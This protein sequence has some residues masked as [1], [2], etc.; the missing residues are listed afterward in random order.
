MFPILKNTPS[1]KNNEL[2]ITDALRTQAKEGNVIAYK[3]KGQRFDCGSIEGFIEA[4]NFV[5][6]K[7]K[8]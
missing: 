3:F 4:T 7:I 5:Y 8:V 2:Q 1:G 6:S